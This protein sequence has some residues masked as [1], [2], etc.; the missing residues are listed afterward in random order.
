MSKALE[1]FG[2][3]PTPDYENAVKEAASAVESAFTAANG[4]KLSM[5]DATRRFAASSDVH[6]AL[7]ES[8]S[9]LFVSA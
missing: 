9:K 5:A 6:S 4:Q 8:A 3:R 7:M 1:K 2:A